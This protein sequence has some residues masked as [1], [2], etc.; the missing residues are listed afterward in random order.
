MSPNAY[1]Q[2]NDESRLLYGYQGE[3]ED[4]KPV[5]TWTYSTFE[6]YLNEACSPSMYNFFTEYICE[7]IN[8]EEL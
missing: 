7:E 3:E 4:E 8:K 6:E 1:V 5:F 2:W